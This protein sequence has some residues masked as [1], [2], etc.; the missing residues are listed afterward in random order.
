MA[1]HAPRPA[2]VVVGDDAMRAFKP[3]ADPL[4]ELATL[5]VVRSMVELESAL[6]TNPRS[7]LVGD[8]KAVLAQRSLLGNLRRVLLV[9]MVF[10][11]EGPVPPPQ[12][13]VLRAFGGNW[14]L[15]ATQP[16]PRD[17]EAL[18]ELARSAR[19]PLDLERLPL[20]VLLERLANSKATAQIT[21]AC[22]H[23]PVLWLSNEPPE[24]RPCVGQSN[25]GGWYGTV[26]VRGGVLVHCETGAGI[27][28]RQA[29][30]QV[31]SVT[32]GYSNVSAV[33]LLPRTPPQAVPPQPR[34]DE[35]QM[36]ELDKVLKVA[37][38]LRGIARSN[39]AGGIEEFTGQLDAESVC[40]VAAMCSQHL[41]KIA[42]LLGCGDLVAWALT[43]EASG[44]YVHQSRDGLVAIV[45]E[46]N[47]NPDAVLRKTGQALKGA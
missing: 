35:A 10:V 1:G 31:L 9:P 12:Q 32:R 40:A 21:I 30:E 47:K 8:A 24:S 41:H 45:G 2:F 36:S 11:N 23:S 28:D 46:T 19:A 26:V 5:H 15:D 43:T 18:V 37:S 33:F 4:D 14:V 42:E 13:Q 17:V 34:K 6:T 38:G 16:T 29:K 27:L 25:C 20:G 3:V 39:S 7:I 22:P 44:F